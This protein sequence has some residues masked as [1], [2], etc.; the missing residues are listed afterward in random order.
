MRIYIATKFENVQGFNV[1][2]EWLEKLGHSITHDWTTEQ[3]LPG[4]SHS[5]P[6]VVAIAEADFKGVADCDALLF[7]AYPKMAGAFSELG[8][9]LGLNKP[10]FVVDA[11]KEGNP[12]N[13]FYSMPDVEHY[14]SLAEAVAAIDAYHFHICYD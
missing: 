12:P 5:T 1:A 13:I 6:R 3:F 4:E 8:I 11:F 7:L 10:I 2:R 9:A 14:N